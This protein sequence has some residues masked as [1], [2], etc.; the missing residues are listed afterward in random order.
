VKKARRRTI[1]RGWKD[2]VE[3]STSSEQDRAVSPV[4]KD[5]SALTHLQS[6]VRQQEP[7]ETERELPSNS[8]D[9]RTADSN[10]SVESSA[11]PNTNGSDSKTCIS[12]ILPREQ[13]SAYKSVSLSLAALLFL[14]MRNQNMHSSPS[15][16]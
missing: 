9:V 1:P 7:R 2:L 4:E 15:V 14:L 13:K 10:R 8:S 12:A 16:V 6:E 5:E 11:L 3:S